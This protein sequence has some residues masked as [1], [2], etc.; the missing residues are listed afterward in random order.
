M[1]FF[2]QGVSLVTKN[3]IHQKHQTMAMNVNHFKKMKTDDLKTPSKS[4]LNIEVK[5]SAKIQVK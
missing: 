1:Y 2:T 4:S 5:R 3:G